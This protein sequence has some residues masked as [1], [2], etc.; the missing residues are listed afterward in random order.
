MRQLEALEE[1]GRRPGQR[2]LRLCAVLA[3]LAGPVAPAPVLAAEPTASQAE[4]GADARCPKGGKLRYCDN[5]DGTVSDSRTGLVW[6]KDA[7]CPTLGP[8]GEGRGTFAEANA[9]AAALRSGQC[10]LSDGSK[11]GDWRLPSSQEWLAMLSPE[12]KNPAIGNADSSRKWK[13]GDAF[14]NIR[15]DGYWSSTP[16]AGN[17][18]FAWGAGLFGGVVASARKSIEGYIWPVRNP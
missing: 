15:S 8:S 12:F 5:G 1:Y 11:P 13:P 18:D 4:G 10:G 16:D 9:S 3:I 6:L 17:T 2:T 7:G 14:M